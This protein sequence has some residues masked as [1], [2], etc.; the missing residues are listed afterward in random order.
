MAVHKRKSITLRN[1]YA[2]TATKLGMYTNANPVTSSFS[3]RNATMQ[4]QK[5]QPDRN[6]Q[7]P[8]FC[9]EVTYQWQPVAC[10]SV[11]GFPSEK[12]FLC[13]EKHGYSQKSTSPF[14][15][16][17]LASGLELPLVGQI[18]TEE[19]CSTTDNYRSN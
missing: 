2:I 14:G 3:A 8:T 18:C 1:V 6:P 4:V 7:S 13:E 16:I 19:L 5:R 17:I 11:T 15:Q 9:L 10:Q 12:N